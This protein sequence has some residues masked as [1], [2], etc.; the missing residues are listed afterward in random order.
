MKRLLILLAL[1]LMLPILP[2]A[3][4][5]ESEEEELIVSVR[6]S[7]VG[8]G[9]NH[10]NVTA[11]FD[12]R[13]VMELRD[14]YTCYRTFDM[15]LTAGEH[16]I[17]WNGLGEH[18]M[19]LP[20]GYYTL[21][22]TLTAPDGAA[23]QAQFTLEIT[24]C[25]QAMVFVLPRHDTLYLDDPELPRWFAEVKL[26]RTGPFCVEFFR[27][28]DLENP[29]SVQKQSVTGAPL[30]EY[31][32]DG[33][34]NNMA[35][36][37]G[38]YVLRFYAEGTPQYVQEARVTVLAGMRPV[39]EVAPT[40]PIM[41]ERCMSDEEIWAMMMKPSVVIN[42]EYSAILQ[43][44]SEPG[45]DAGKPVGEIHGASQA[46]EVLALRDGFALVGA[47]RHEDGAYVEG[48]VS[49]S[50]LTVVEP[51]PHYGL[52]IDKQAQSMTIY[53]HGQPIGVTPV[54]TGRITADH[55]R[56]ETPAGAYLLLEHLTPLVD[57]D[58]TYDHRIRYDGEGVLEQT[59]FVLREDGQHFT[60]QEL[61][62]GLKSS[63]GSI[64]LPQA[65]HDGI[66]AYWLW[67]H[68]PMGTRVMI[69]DDPVERAHRLDFVF[70][71]VS[72]LQ[73][74]EA[75]PLE[76]GD[77]ELV[78][79]VGGD[80]ALGTRETWWRS[81]ESFP[82]YIT[83]FGYDYPFAD[84]QSIFAHDDMTLVNLECVLK[85]DGSNEDLEKAMRFRGLPEYARILTAGSIEQ[86]N[87]ANNHY[88]DYGMEG[89]DATRAALEAEGILYSG[90]G[91]IHVW[92]AAGFKIGFGGCR[93]S[94]YFSNPVVIERDVAA[95]RRAGCDVIVYSCH[96]GTEYS[97]HHNAVQEEIALAA[98]AAGVDII[99][100]THPHVVQGVGTVSDTVVLWSLG[101]LSFG[102]THSSGMRTYDAMLAQFRLRFDE[103]G[104]KGC[105][106]EIIPILTSGTD[107]DGLNDYRP[108]IAFPTEKK[109]IMALIQKDSAFPLTDSMYFPAP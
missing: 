106:L 43:L 34:I 38:E 67:T 33:T 90:Y 39:S 32:W 92:E 85:A 11:P 89:R 42:D 77:V 16:E 55:L 26:V 53:H 24:R 52:L 81:E 96:W 58:Y 15:A 18:D 50:S 57:G 2:M 44:R 4:Q 104:Y 91:Y 12:G 88:I 83:N 25:N 35:V 82:S 69:L 17:F 65:L 59:G 86:V 70:G 102:G 56:R 87:I 93:E 62:L 8:F 99:V 63:A 40:G 84:L 29:I 3:A 51:N 101:N 66:N 108:Y 94:T 6:Y 23:L 75:P 79:T 5:A 1:L 19:R 109:R 45:E 95:L 13:L 47:W 46:L 14:A 97:E 74:I 37:P 41:A 68:L 76:E 72:H 73:P 20:E 105:A 103:N 7:V 98:A 31:T 61:M 22:A 28:E 60:T 64:R 48:Y 100:G 80:A 54:S 21:H 9:I 78:L 49:A 30:L 10:I 107:Y 27:A 71:Q 36:E